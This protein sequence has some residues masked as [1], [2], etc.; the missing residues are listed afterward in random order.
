MLYTGVTAGDQ[1]YARA[2]QGAF[3]MAEAPAR[4]CATHFLRF[5]DSLDPQVERARRLG[6]ASGW[7]GFDSARQLGRGFEAKAADFTETLTG[8]Q[9]SALR[10]AA[11]YLLAAGLIRDADDSHSRALLAAA[12]DL[13]FPG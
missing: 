12:A 3:R 6:G 2:A 10:M 13:D 9:D 7:G 5:A 1:L 4:R 8:L 11:A